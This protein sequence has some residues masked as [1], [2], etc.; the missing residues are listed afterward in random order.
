MGLSYILVHG[1]NVENKIY[2][3]DLVLKEYG[4]YEKIG[5]I[6]EKAK[7]HSGFKNI[8]REKCRGEAIIGNSQCY[9]ELKGTDIVT[10][11]SKSR[12]INSAIDKELVY[13]IHMLKGIDNDEQYFVKF[14]ITKDG[15]VVFINELAPG[16]NGIKGLVNITTEDLKKKGV[17]EI[18]SVMPFKDYKYNTA[19]LYIKTKDKE[20]LMP[21]SERYKDTTLENYKLYEVQEVI[22]ILKTFYNPNATDNAREKDPW[23][24]IP[25]EGCKIRFT[26]DAVAKEEAIKR[27]EREIIYKYLKSDEGY[28]LQRK[29][30]GTS[31]RLDGYAALYDLQNPD[32]VAAY[33]EKGSV[34]ANFTKRYKWYIYKEK[35]LKLPN[36]AFSVDG[37]TKKAKFIENSTDILSGIENMRNNIDNYLN[38]EKYFI[39]AG[40]KNVNAIRYFIV[41]KYRTSFIYIEGDGKEFLIPYSDRPMDTTLN[42]NKLYIAKEVID[43]LERYYN[44]N[45]TEQAER[46]ACDV[47]I[48]DNKGNVIIAIG[49]IALTVIYII[50]KIV[51]K[52]K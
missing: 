18:L 35:N 29:Y 21:Y 22:K 24:D 32:I 5:D 15:E 50:I 28:E 36:L 37:K 3:Q 11:F 44:P 33:K 7:N 10:A 47:I 30:L 38:L 4:I 42:N 43:K 31:S 51:K 40:I 1:E 46:W 52:K 2:T 25:I 45:R 14:K 41:P 49:V 20:Y 16:D 23:F 27:A 48:D 12:N 39:E 17:D 34:A 26:S 13:I 19:F 6:H 9:Y 8:L